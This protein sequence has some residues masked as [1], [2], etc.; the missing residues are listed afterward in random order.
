[1]FHFLDADTVNIMEPELR[2]NK[3]I[4]INNDISNINNKK[5]RNLSIDVDT[6]DENNKAEN[7]LAVVN[8]KI[9][10]E[11]GVSPLDQTKKGATRRQLDA[12]Q[13]KKEKELKEKEKGPG[14]YYEL[15]PVTNPAPGPSL[16]PAFGQF[17]AGRCCLVCK[18]PGG[19]VL[20]CTGQCGDHYHPKCVS[21]GQ[22]VIQDQFK[23][24]H[25][26][27]GQHACAI[28]GKTDGHVI[29][30]HVLSCGKFYH[31]MCLTRYTIWPQHKISNG[32]VFCPDHTCHTCASD[33]PHDPVMKYNENLV[34][35]IHC[36]TAYHSG[37]QCIAAGTIQLT[38]IDI[39]CPKHYKPQ[40]VKSKKG[41]SSSHVHSNW[42][43]I[44]SKGGNLVLCEKCPAAF[45]EV[46]LG[47]TS[48]LV[49]DKY[50]CE[51]CQSG[52]LP[53]YNDVVW[54]K[55]GV[56][57]WWPA[58]ILHPSNVPDNIQKVGLYI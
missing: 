30:C 40:S 15:V 29:K 37:D 45:H 32:H 9:R 5:K 6:N 58:Y 8:K 27:S 11:P 42:C 24:G 35:C 46:C 2:M 57:R 48:E 16:A 1:M 19:Q 43:F 51:V 50:Y 21:E 39:I 20:R 41:S 14:W 34:H 12:I 33:N 22:E 3:M 54:A 56:Y 10:L 49:E 13:E 28:C 31:E 17:V 52:R 44:C 25:C 36:P 23:C 55:W 47:L 4:E 53:L 26:K 38:K 7:N 18:E